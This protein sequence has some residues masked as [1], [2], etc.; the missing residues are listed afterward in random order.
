MCF[1][2]AILSTPP[3]C[4]RRHDYDGSHLSVSLRVSLS[5]SP[6]LFS[7]SGL[8]QYKNCVVPSLSSRKHLR[9]LNGA[10]FPFF[11]PIGPLV[12][13]RFK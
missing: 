5:L 4:P 11:S 1:I 6:S 10:G 9:T 2:R 3:M 8:A 12:A 13:E 7:R